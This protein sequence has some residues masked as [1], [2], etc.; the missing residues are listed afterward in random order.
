MRTFIFVPPLVKMSGGLAVL[1]QVAGH[2][3]KAGYEVCLV[4][5]PPPAQTPG[6]EEQR[7]TGLQVVTFD[8]LQLCSS[9]ILLVPDGCPNALAP[10]INAGARTLVYT[11]GWSQMLSILPHKVRWQDLPVSFI[12]VSDPVSW[13]MERM[14]GLSVAGMI[15]PAIDDVFK[16]GDKPD[17]CVRIAWMPRKNRVLAEQIRQ[18]VD[19]SMGKY[20]DAPILDWVPIR[21]LPPS[22]VAELLSTCHLFLA[23]AFPEGFG[24]PSLEAMACGAVPVGFTGFG[25]WDYMRQGLPGLYESPLPLCERPWSGNGLYASDGDVLN[26]S[27]LL[28]KAVGMVVN[29]D[30]LLHSMREQGLKAA[31]AYSS[32]VQ[33]KAIMLLWQGFAAASG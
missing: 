28:E 31:Q 22:G 7:A 26:A 9:D 27:I 2:L 17:K 13:F 15:P 3:R 20:Y 16:P 23:A 1:Y 29:N 12:S 14:L 18:I 5:I 24:L 4:A 10:G 6:L 30:P 25:G 32:E 11:Q 8:K 19:F 33:S 21:N